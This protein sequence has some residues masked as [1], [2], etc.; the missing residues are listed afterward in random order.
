MTLD[1][2]E[3]EAAFSIA[4][5]YFERGGGEPFLVVGTGVKTTLQPKGCKEG[6]LRVYAI[7]EQGRVLEFLHKVSGI[8]LHNIIGADPF[9]FL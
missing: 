3:D 5:A 8:R 7:K 9:A 2:D 1:L 6:Y 4:I